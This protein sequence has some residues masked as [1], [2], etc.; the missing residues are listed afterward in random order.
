[1][2]KY[3]LGDLRFM[4]HTYEATLPAEV[5]DLLVHL[6]DRHGAAVDW[7]EDCETH[8]GPM[9]DPADDGPAAHRWRRVDAER[10]S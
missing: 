1:M 6:I 7:E 2:I 9:P 4:A 10:R 5:A 8:E 3:T